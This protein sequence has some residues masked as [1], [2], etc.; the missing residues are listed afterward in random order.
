MNIEVA[1]A[2]GT[3]W[4]Q[5]REWSDHQWHYFHSKSTDSRSAGILLMMRNPCSLS[6]T[7]S[8]SLIAG[9]LFHARLH[10][11]SCPLD[12]VLCYQ[13]STSTTH[14]GKDLPAGWWTALDELMR[15]LPYRNTLLC[16]G[17][18][19]CSLPVIP[20]RV[21]VDAFRSASVKLIK[22]SRHWFAH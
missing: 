3:H 5:D 2:V 16:L 13:Y 21:T 1:C 9:K 8:R 17:D 18:F 12:L 22:G 4:Y 10:L 14:E 11:A 6:V 20:H 19:N 15:A 7:A